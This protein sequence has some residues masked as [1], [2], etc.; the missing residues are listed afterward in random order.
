MTALVPQSV[1]EP[2]RVQS[3]DAPP[4]SVVRR[5]T[6]PLGR[7]ALLVVVVAIISSYFLLPLLWLIINATKSNSQMINSFGF[8]F[9][10]PS[11]LFANFSKLFSS[12]DGIFLRWM[13]NSFIYSGVTAL[14]ST[15]IC[16]CA[17]FAFAKYRFRGQR[18]LYAVVLAAVMVPNTA[19]V[20][21]VF[22]LM[23]QLQLINT[24]W[25]VILPSL[26]NPLGFYLASLFWDQSL[27]DELI[28]AA[29]IDGAGDLRIFWSVGLPL[30]RNGLTTIALLAFVGAW[31]NLFL[32]LI[33][34]S[35]T[36]LFPVVQGLAAWN[37][38]PASGVTVDYGV[39][40]LGAL[41]SVIP[42]V[43]AFIW[44]ARYWQAGIAVGATKG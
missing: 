8:W 15:L 9:A 34:L 27:P 17:G 13:G 11:N 30:L 18:P 4:R 37:L 23:N 24:Y 10:S 2:E 26:V 40:L 16:A 14:L 1:R 43:A 44:L 6:S 41:I 38:A 29:R 19:L 20:L 22:L 31:N 33:V 12:E 35:K 5:P 3:A 28:D 32:P 21:P 42:L 25:A 39:V 7:R 36:E